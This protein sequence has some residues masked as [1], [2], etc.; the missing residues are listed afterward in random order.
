MVFL[1]ILINIILET[2]QQMSATD[3]N[4]HFDGK[5]FST[6]ARQDGNTSII[7][8]APSISAVEKSNSATTI[9]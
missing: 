6:V 3:Q 9:L 4:R 8:H 7:V 2:L 1:P 5:S